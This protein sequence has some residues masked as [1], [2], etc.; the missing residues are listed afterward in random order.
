MTTCQHSS[1]NSTRVCVVQHL[2]ICCLSWGKVS[3]GHHTVA[4][5]VSFEMCVCLHE[6]VYLLS[7]VHSSDF[8]IRCNLSLHRHLQKSLPYP[9][10]KFQAQRLRDIIHCEKGPNRWK[11]VEG[12]TGGKAE[13]GGTPAEDPMCNY[14]R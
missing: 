10:L 1:Q 13:L 9:G 6:Y 7:E 5:F 11:I 12:Q 14:S 3:T 8:T 4:T 2:V